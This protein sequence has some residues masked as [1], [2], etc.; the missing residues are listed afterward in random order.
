M[1]FDPR[2][3]ARILN[4][5]PRPFRP[6]TKER[7]LPLNH[8][9]LGNV[10]I[11]DPDRRAILR[12]LDE[13]ALSSPNTVNPPVSRFRDIIRDEYLCFVRA[14]GREIAWAMFAGA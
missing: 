8:F 9:D 6:A 14:D 2:D 11:A 3:V 1:L 7:R 13:A 5:S 4:S 10:L 12:T